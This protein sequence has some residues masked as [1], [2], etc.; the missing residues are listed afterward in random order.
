[1]AIEATPARVRAIAPWRDSEA[2]RAAVRIGLSSRMAVLLVA[3][4]AALSFGPASGGLA[5]RE[6]R[7]VRRPGAHARARRPAARAAGPLGL[8]LV[9]ARSPTRATAAARRAPR[10][11]RSTRCW[12][13]AWA[14]S[15][16]ART[17]R[18]WSPRTCVSLAAFLGGA[19]RSCTGSPS[20]SSAAGSRGRRCCCSRCSRPRS[21]SAR[22]TR[23]ACS[24][25]WRWARS[26]PRGPAA[27]PGRAP[28][29]GLASATRSAGLLLLLPLALIWWTSRPRRAARRRLAPAGAARDR[30]VRRVARAGGGRRAPLPGRAGGV[31]ASSSPVPLAGAWD[32]LVAA[33]RRRAPA[34][35]GLAHARLLRQGGG[36]PVPDR[37]HQRDAVRVARVRGGRRASACSGGCRAPT[38]CGSRPRSC[39]R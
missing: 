20:S 11:S 9:P 31:V 7:Q 37:R 24:S 28:C 3:I 12:C 19:R 33:V 2:V 38:G 6:R 13:G 4:F 35:V 1:M 21:T 39:C 16:A 27:G 10:S 14:P 32:G 23:R 18:C 26:T 15:S 22:R 17:R 5:R 8:G 34:R 25:C 36:R 30:R 29:A